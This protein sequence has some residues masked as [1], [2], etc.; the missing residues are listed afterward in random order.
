[1]KFIVD[2]AFEAAMGGAGKNNGEGESTCR[3]CSTADDRSQSLVSSRTAQ[4]CLESKECFCAA[5][6]P[7][8]QA[9]ADRLTEDERQAM[10]DYTCGDLCDEMNLALRKQDASVPLQIEVKVQLI[11][12][13]LSKL[14]PM[15]SGTCLWRGSGSDLAQFFVLQPGQVFWDAGCFST[16]TDESI[17]M[18]FTREDGDDLEGIMFSLTYKMSGKAIHFL[19][20]CCHEAE[21]LYPPSTK[22]IITK[23][24]GNKVFMTELVEDEVEESVVSLISGA[25]EEPEAA[26]ISVTVHGPAEDDEDGDAVEEEIIASVQRIASGQRLRASKTMNVAMENDGLCTLFV[27]GRRR[28]ARLQETVRSVFKM[29]ADDPLS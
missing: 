14:P 22:F 6:C 16:S 27:D 15:K 13:G 12:K 18:N 24:D 23:L 10:Y 4:S 19:S 29:D 28:L 2:E 3:T 7:L 26:I 17:A 11:T 8:R 21:V 20:A 9:Q 1:M 25:E 5:K